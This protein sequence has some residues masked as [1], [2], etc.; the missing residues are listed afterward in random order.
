MKKKRTLLRPLGS[1]LAMGVPLLLGILLKD[2]LISSVGAMG[3]FSYL[4]FQHISFLYNFKAILLHG[5]ALLL[6]FILGALTALAPWSA[7]FI[8]GCFVFFG[9]FTFKSL[10]HPKTRLFLCSDALCNWV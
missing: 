9:F 1:G 6:A 3:A 8:I 5:G 10:S 2:P 4:A 7:P